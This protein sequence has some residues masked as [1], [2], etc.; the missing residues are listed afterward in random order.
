MFLFV[1]YL[2]SSWRIWKDSASVL[3]AWN[4]TSEEQNELTLKYCTS[5]CNH[6]CTFGSCWSHYNWMTRVFLNVT[7]NNR[8]YLLEMLYGV[9]Q[10]FTLSLISKQIQKHFHAKLLQQC[11]WLTWN[12]AWETTHQIKKFPWAL[13]I[14]EV[15]CLKQQL[16]LK[17]YR[18]FMISTTGCRE[19]HHIERL[20]FVGQ[21]WAV[22]H[23]YVSGGNHPNPCVENITGLG[24]A[25]CYCLLNQGLL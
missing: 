10:K 12:I 6:N 15:I 14:S 19:M 23:I 8:S 18:D 5:E 22:C 2:W 9:Y 4:Y 7:L 11:A 21:T 20:R 16:C 24:S 17:V 25:L 3:I 13:N 1:L